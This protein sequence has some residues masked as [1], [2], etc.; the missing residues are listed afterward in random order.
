MAGI[1]PATMGP[2]RVVTLTAPETELP[3]IEQALRRRLAEPVPITAR[4]FSCAGTLSA[5][6]A[7]AERSED[8]LRQSEGSTAT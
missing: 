3:G 4:R 8:I 1:R 6:H 5:E 7:L 2:V